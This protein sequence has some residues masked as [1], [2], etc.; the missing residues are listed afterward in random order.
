MKN[1]LPLVFS[2][3]LAFTSA[4]QADPGTLKA[5]QC[6]RAQIERYDSL[7][8]HGGSVSQMESWRKARAA[9]EDKFRKAE[10]KKY[11]KATRKQG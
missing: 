6:A 9:Q 11:G 4:V 3:T 10:C 1:L 5:C 8:R 7:R 2:T